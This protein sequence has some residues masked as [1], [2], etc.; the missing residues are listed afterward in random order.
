MDPETWLLTSVLLSV[1]VARVYPVTGVIVQVD[2]AP[3][4]TGVVQLIL[5]PL[6]VTAVPMVNVGRTAVPDSAAVSVGLVASLLVTCRVA[7]FVPALVGAKMTL[8]VQLVPAVS[9]GVRLAH[10]D[11][12]PVATLNW[13]ALVPVRVM[14]E[15]VTE[16]FV[17]P[18]INAKVAGADWVPVAV[19]VKV[20]VTGV[21][22]RVEVAN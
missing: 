22:E 7:L 2:E 6:P 19:A 21:R 12:P 11:E 14:A 1:R 15:T 8:T 18:L 17:L 16:G 4:F 9:V 10:G 3:W 5:P 20:V 13:L